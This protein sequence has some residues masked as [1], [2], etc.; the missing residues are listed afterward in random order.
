VYARSYSH[1]ADSVMPRGANI[2]RSIAN[3]ADGRVRAGKIASPLESATVNVR[4][5]L[6]L[7]AE[8]QEIE[9][10]QQPA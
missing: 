2:R 8:R 5:A 1:D 6:Q 9:M 3:R 7:I 4:A 10:L